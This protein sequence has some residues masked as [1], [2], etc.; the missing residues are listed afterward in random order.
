MRKRL[1]FQFPQP[2]LWP[3]FLNRRSQVRILSGVL[4]ASRF[5]IAERNV[6][7][8]GV[9]NRACV[10]GHNQW[11]TTNHKHGNERT[12]WP[13][14]ARPGECS[15]R[16]RRTSFGQMR[17]SNAR[18]SSSSKAPMRFV[19]HGAPVGQQESARKSDWPE[20]HLSIATTRRRDWSRRRF[21]KHEGAVTSRNSARQDLFSA[22][23]A[24]MSIPK[25]GILEFTILDRRKVSEQAHMKRV[26]Q[27]DEHRRRRRASRFDN[28]IAGSQFAA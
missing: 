4:Y 28:A 5:L 1:C 11:Q 15:R 22:V 23:I 21:R 14:S 2:G 9:V 3:I 17:R 20:R 10:S 18:S 13:S 27:Q 16:D 12:L 7:D 24:I 19:P 25:Q 26:R 8:S 6:E